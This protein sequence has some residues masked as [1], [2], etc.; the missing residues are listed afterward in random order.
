[1]AAVIRSESM[2][3]IEL[4]LESLIKKGGVFY[5]IFERDDRET[6]LIVLFFEDSIMD[7][8][9]EK[10]QMKTRLREFDC[11]L[12]FKCYAR[13]CFKSFNGR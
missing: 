12:E 10:M 7:T 4:E 2:N 9:A 6:K 1:V 8:M 13:D 3:I 11:T 5:E